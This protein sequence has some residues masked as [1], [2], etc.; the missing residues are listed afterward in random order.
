MHEVNE[1][2]HEHFMRRCIELARIALEGGDTPVGSV[3]VREGRIL[4][5]GVEAVRALCDVTAH[6]E[7]EAVRAACRLARTLDLS[8]STLYTTVAPCAMC[9]YAIRQCHIGTVVSGTR[10]MKEEGTSA[11]RLILSEQNIPRE[12]LPP[13]L[14]YGVLQDECLALLRRNP[15]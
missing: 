11:A 15:S 7:V 12:S 2:Q 14:I 5:E 6:A 9:A 4:A 3:I 10:T 1:L 8:G 13:E